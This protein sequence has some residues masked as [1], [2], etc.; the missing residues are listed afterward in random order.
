[1]ATATQE[2][3]SNLTLSNSAIASQVEIGVVSGLFAGG[4][5]GVQMLLAEMMPMIASMIGSDS[6]VI[7]FII[8]MLISAVIGGTYGIIAARLPRTL[9]VQVAGGL[10]YGIVW[11]VLGALVIMPTV[12]GMGE[13]VLNVT[14]AL[15]SLIGHSIFGIFM[16][17]VYVLLRDKN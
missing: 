9:L 11:W 13:M 17:V 3:T 4:I 15:G 10:I 16:A 7:G 1:M 2:K 12:L 8:H 5:F 14:P 6:I